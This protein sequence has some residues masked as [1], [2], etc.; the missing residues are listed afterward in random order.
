MPS[1][2]FDDR[3]GCTVAPADDPENLR[4]RTFLGD[5]LELSPVHRFHRNP[6]EDEPIGRRME[7]LVLRREAERVDRFRLEPRGDDEADDRRDEGGD[8]DAV[9]LR[10]L[11]EEE[12]CRERRV[13][14][15][16]EKCAE[17]DERIGAPPLGEPGQQ[18][19]KRG[20]P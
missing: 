4:Q 8:G 18:A 16:G 13:G 2:R 10:H 6:I 15:G 14:G 7:T 19:R 9:T 3:E 17:T 1:T 5:G 20:N 12:D 11:E